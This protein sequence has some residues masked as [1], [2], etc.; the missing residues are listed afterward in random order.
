MT[1]RTLLSYLATK[2]LDEPPQTEADF[3]ARLEQ[4]A[5]DNMFSPEF[6]AALEKALD[7][8][9]AD[10]PPRPTAYSRKLALIQGGKR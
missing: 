6:R 8:C 5:Y 4:E 7:I 1:L 2:P 9:Y 10:K 3:R